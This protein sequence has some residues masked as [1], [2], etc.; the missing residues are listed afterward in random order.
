MNRFE[1]NAL[2]ELHV[3]KTCS[4]DSDWS[5]ISHTL[6]EA[7]IN[8]MNLY[9]KILLYIIIKIYNFILNIFPYFEYLLKCKEK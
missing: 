1:Y 5:N 6:H 8:S 2:G 9:I 7:Q 4:S 3:I